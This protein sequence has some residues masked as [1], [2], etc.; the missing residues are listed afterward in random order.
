[1]LMPAYPGTFTIPPF[2]RADASK[3][4]VQKLA[5]SPDG[6]WLA[7]RAEGDKFVRVFDVETGKDKQAFEV[8][9]PVNFASPLVFSPDGCL[10]VYCPGSD[11]KLVLWDVVTGKVRESYDCVSPAPIGLSG[12]DQSMLQLQQ[13]WAQQRD[14]QGIR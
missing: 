12:V 10:A 5:L 1:M 2:E 6:K 14:G 9:F 7:S 8:P 11:R 3:V 13:Q 4:A